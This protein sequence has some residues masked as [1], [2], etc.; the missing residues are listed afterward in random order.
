MSTETNVSAQQSFDE[1]VN[2][3][4]FDAVET[5]VAPDSVDH[6]PAPGQEPGPAGYRCLFGEMRSD[7]GRHLTST[8]QPGSP[9]A[10]RRAQWGESGATVL[11]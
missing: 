4:D 11:R 7:I 2:K 6:D 8:T 5:L 1:A 9:A 3:G 10:A